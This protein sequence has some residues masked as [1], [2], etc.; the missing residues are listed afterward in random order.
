MMA[1]SFDLSE[2]T[3]EFLKE[4]LKDGGVPSFFA[5]LDD[6]AVSASPSP[7]VH[8]EL[9]KL[10]ERLKALTPESGAKYLSPRMD[11]LYRSDIPMSGGRD[12]GM[13]GSK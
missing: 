12:Q 4:R 3:K 6:L 13:L 8:L 5:A 11:S 2:A 9:E 10:R 1:R 7:Q